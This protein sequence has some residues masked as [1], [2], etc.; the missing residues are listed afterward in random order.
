MQ[1]REPPTPAGRINVKPAAAIFLLSFLWACSTLRPELLPAPTASPATSLPTLERFFLPFAF[2]TL[3]AATRAI[4]RHE[5][6]PRASQVRLPVLVALGIFVV[7]PLMN[8]LPGIELDAYTRT[9]LFTTIPIFSLIFEPYIVPISSPQPRAALLAALAALFGA[10][11][12][13]P[14]QFPNSPATVAGFFVAIF[15]ALSIAIANC[16]AARPLPIGNRHSFTAIAS[17]TSAI[18]CAAMS[19]GIRHDTWTFPQLSELLWIL[20]VEFPA[21]LIL[22]WLFRYT[23]A[24]RSSTRYLL[25]PLLAIL[26][27]AA[28]LR[29]PLIVRTSSGLALVAAGALYLLFAPQRPSDESS[30]TGLSLR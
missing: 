14:M 10:L 25:A 20:T 30:S 28:L 7:P 12:V 5:P 15:T 22:F 17:A 8:T 11:C 13:F 26:A 21:L 4:L 16:F 9:V 2:L 6:L 19:L 3:I 24:I 1:Q 29:Q 27:G 23:S 18:C